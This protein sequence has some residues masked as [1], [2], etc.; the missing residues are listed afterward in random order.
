MVQILDCIW[1]PNLREGVGIN[2]KVME[3]VME[4]VVE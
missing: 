4:C 1:N 2:E 3:W